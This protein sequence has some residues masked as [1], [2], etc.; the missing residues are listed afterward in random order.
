MIAQTLHGYDQGHR[1]LAQG[2]DVDDTELSLLDRLSDLSGYV[3]LGTDFDRYH[4]GFACGR[5]Y[6]FA[7][8]WPDKEATRAGTVLTH[9]LLVPRDALSGINDLWML[10]RWHRRPRSAAERGGYTSAIAANFKV[11][12]ENAPT[13]A[14]ERTLSA[15]ALWFGQPERP[16][17]WVEDGRPEDVVRYLWH[18][19]WPEAREGFSFCTFAL[20]VRYLR[21]DPFGFLALPP[22]ARGAFHERAGSAAWWQ[23]GRPSSAAV[24][25][26][27]R[28]PWAQ[29][30]LERGA[31]VTLAMPRFCEAQ[32]VPPLD[33]AQFPIFRRFLELEEP[34]SSRLTAARARADLLH[35]LWPELDPTHPL[36]RATLRTLL[37]RQADAPLS[38][39]PFWELGDMLE[40]PAVRALAGADAK[41]ASTLERTLEREVRRRLLEAAPDA[42]SGVATLM[43]HE[44]EHGGRRAI[45]GGVGAAFESMPPGNAAD[46]RVIAIL[47][48]SPQAGGS[49]LAHTALATLSQDRR[50]HVALQALE[51]APGEARPQLVDSLL[52]AAR[53]L[54]D[55]LLIA[56]VWI[57]QDE[58][59]RG[60]REAASI[61]L[62]APEANPER[63]RPVLARLNAE[64]RLAWAL[65]AAEPPLCAWAGA[66]GAEAAQELQVPARGVL[67]RCRGAPNGAHVALAYLVALPPSQLRHEELL[68]PAIAEMLA[69]DAAALPEAKRLVD[70]LAPHLIRQLCESALA[71]GDAAGW[72]RQAAV[73]DHLERV[74][75]W[76]LFSAS[77]VH[78]AHRDCL[79]NLARGVAAYVR[80]EPSAQIAWVQNLLGLPLGA[81]GP[82]NLARAAGDLAGLL[83]LPPD[84]RG[85][86]LLA[87]D[88]LAAVRRTGCP[89]AHQLVELTFPVLYPRLERGE[90]APGPRARLGGF[91]WYTWDLAKSWRHWLLDCWLDQQWPPAAF[92]RCLGGDQA[93]FRRLADRAAETRRGR[94][95]LVSLRD[96]LAE[97]PRLAERWAVPV[98]RVL[99][100]PG[101]PRG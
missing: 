51:A 17:L 100:G 33:E 86:L 20:Q 55:P 81:A 46:A 82:S 62:S 66:R 71:S 24:R 84:R 74:D 53:S 36:V 39:R 41:F 87:A 94:E 85:W 16:V 9:T 22:A 21:R 13:P 5:Y 61:V 58:P 64:I 18:L 77:G 75:P 6:A 73:Q 40:R 63:L 97:N 76:A 32:A 1:L 27:T 29:A 2:G 65:E 59:M 28:Q 93:L 69:S 15:I 8:T 31:E 14:P 37:E 44:P 68:T 48:A 19:L 42:A 91:P 45:L 78:P 11:E 10:A 80:S 67:E 47:L 95:L 70:R 50:A 26:R 54:A 92:L 72:L 56:E 38:P 90:L 89:A 25:E 30:I 3:P 49:P 96:A 83:A 101:G 23:D 60:A 99:G 52:R 34:A 35:R 43:A 12:A 57:A 7:C 4:T 79:P 98:A 88:V